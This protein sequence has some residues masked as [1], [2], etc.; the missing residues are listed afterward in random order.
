MAYRRVYT[1]E[2]AQAALRR[3]PRELQKE[4][5]EA[6]E[7]IAQDISIEA[8]SRAQAVGGVAK[9]V[10]RTVKAKRDRYPVIV[11]GGTARSLPS[12][13]VVGDVW[14]GAEF[15]SKRYRQFAPFNKRGRFMYPAVRDRGD[16]AVTRWLDALQASLESI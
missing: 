15:G 11:M 5:R 10:G 12:G 9:Y 3:L 4:M 7:D 6:S 13:G 2:G 1:V 16:E 14:G 8:S